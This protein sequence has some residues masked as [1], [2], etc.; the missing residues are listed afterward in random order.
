MKK[1]YTLLFALLFGFT[2][3]HGQQ[4]T[5]ENITTNPGRFNHE[6]V[7]IEG[8]VTKYV[9]GTA[10]T[11]SYYELQGDYGARIRVNT[12][13][14]APQINKRY[15][16]TGTVTM[17]M[18]EPLIIEVSKTLL[19]DVITPPPPP[20]QSDNTMMIVLIVGL[21]VVA[22]LII[23]FLNRPKPA[24]AVAEVGTS[25][26]P[27]SLPP[28]GDTVIINKGESYDTIKFES[29]VPSTMKFI[30][31]K[32]EII[33]G[34]DK[35]KSFMLAG[36]PT[37]DGSISSIGRDHEGWDKSLSGGRKYAHIRIKDDSKTLSR[38]Q[39][40]IVY[41]SGKV[42]LKNLSNVNPSQADGYDVPVNEMVEVK[43]G[44]VIKA[45]FIEFRYQA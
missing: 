12:S 20:P 17:H 13:D 9:A 18:Q 29:T 36:Y 32:L 43:S 38:M 42:Y 16:V 3:I 41:R 45:G 30:P 27:P 37:P 2:A 22:G 24:P 33:N 39:A 40:E 21:A 7:V 35:G 4:T 19:D 5:I 28:S 1:N 15:R 31:G 10:T 44:S 8:F 23:F 6:R 25:S 34:P 11:S 26:V 14:P